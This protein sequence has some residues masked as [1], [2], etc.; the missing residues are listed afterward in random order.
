M[1]REEILKRG[2][3]SNLDE[4]EKWIDDHA[5][6]VGVSAFLVTFIALVIAKLAAGQPT[7]DL[8]ALFWAYAAT[9]VY[10]RYRHK[11]QSAL[12]AT[13]ILSGFCA[14]ANL[15]AALIGLFAGG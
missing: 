4:R 12:L 7:H 8:Q 11:K 5:K 9:E 3:E 2:R 10:C 1:D 13:A 15:A 6:I 14:L